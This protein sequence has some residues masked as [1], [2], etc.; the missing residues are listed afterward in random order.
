VLGQELDEPA[1]RDRFQSTIPQ[2]LT[3][4]WNTLQAG[5]EGTAQEALELFIEVA[6]AHPRFLRRSLTEIVNAM[7][8]VFSNMSQ[9]WHLS[10]HIICLQPCMPAAPVACIT[11]SPIDCC[12][13]VGLL[14]HHPAVYMKLPLGPELE[15]P[16]CKES[17]EAT[18]L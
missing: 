14:W 3:V 18:E 13:T 15:E 16:S 11:I 17:S 10:Y 4:I 7:L 12:E 5:D 9:P 8:Q 1:E 2:Q 6:E